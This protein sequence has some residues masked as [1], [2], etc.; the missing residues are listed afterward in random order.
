MSFSKTTV[1]EGTP[2]FNKTQLQ[3]LAVG[4]QVTPLG[5]PC[6]LCTCQHHRAVR[7]QAVAPLGGTISQPP[8]E[9]NSTQQCG[10]K[11]RENTLSSS[12]S[13]FKSLSN[14]WGK[15][16]LRSMNHLAYNVKEAQVEGPVFLS[17][18]SLLL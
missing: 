7:T 4:P 14:A 15:L 9:P 11:Q 17:K 1:R 10:R 5:L 13:V 2:F 16:H 6:I 3:A 8:T 12:N 18:L